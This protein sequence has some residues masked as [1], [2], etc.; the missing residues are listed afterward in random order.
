MIEAV[1]AR[2]DTDSTNLDVPLF[3]AVDPEALNDLVRTADAGSD[4]SPLRIEFTYYGYD[5]SVSADGSVDV[6]ADR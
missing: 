6:S 4:R 1:A 2:E 3:E 5:V